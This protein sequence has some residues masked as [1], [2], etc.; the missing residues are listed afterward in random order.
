MTG[1]RRVLVVQERLPHYRVPFFEQLRSRLA[2]DGV[3]L[4]LAHGRGQAAMAARGDE[5]E[6]SWAHVVDNKM[7]GVGGHSLVWQPVRSLAAQAE[8]VIVEQASR[9]AVNYA[10]LARQAAG[11]SRV[12]FWGHG[13][14]L[15]TD[16]SRVSRLSEAAKARYSRLPHWW[17]AYTEG[18]ARRVEDLGFPHDRITVVQNAVDTSLIEATVVDRDPNRC[19]FVG[20]LYA[21]KRLDLLFAAADRV[22][23]ELPSFR[24]VMVGAGPMRAYV[25]A[26]S[27]RR[28]F[29]DYLGPKFGKDLAI[30]LKSSSLMLLPG[31]AGLGI[32][33]AFAAGLPVVTATGSHHGPELEYVEDGV[34]GLVSDGS[35]ARLT[36]DTLRLL[37]P[38]VA[39]GFRPACAAASARL[40]LDAMT[41]RFRAGV[42]AALTPQLMSRSTSHG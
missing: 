10:L 36:A 9:M 18:S 24:L 42:L 15:Q 39:D 11:G 33:D 1:R 8:L 14:N 12:A 27:V 28:P 19:I 20:G 2:Q 30:E 16:G 17:F 23:S 29:V 21:E 13:A 26:E 3:D 5:A 34:N 32:L 22:A 4:A 37:A 6:L 7:V 38:G 35:V 25:E 40:T 31:A 41:E